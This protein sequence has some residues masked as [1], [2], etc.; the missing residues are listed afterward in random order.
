MFSFNSYYFNSATG[1]TQ[2][3]RPAEM[4]AAPTATG[5]LKFV[6]YHIAILSLS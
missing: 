4:G 5:W 1:V 6:T 2:W 3:E